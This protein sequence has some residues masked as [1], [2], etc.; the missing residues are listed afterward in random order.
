MTGQLSFEVQRRL[1]VAVARLSG[2]LD[3]YTAADLRTGLLSC[4]AE[5]PSAIVMDTTALT[6]ADDIGLLALAGVAQLSERWPGCGF[7]AFG[8]AAEFAPA[9]ERM[10]VSQYVKMCPDLTTALTEADQWPVP[11]TARARI[12]PDRNAPSVARAAVHEFCRVEGIGGDG[13]A[14][15]LVASELVTNA[16]VHAGTTIDLTLRLIPPLLHIAVRDGGRG[17]ARIG[18]VVDESSES[19]RGLLLVDALAASW[20]TF[21]PDAGKVVWATVRVKPRAASALAG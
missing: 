4:L 14:A 19:G 16:V 18:G 12:D 1:P 10:G 2:V 5:Q 13:D 6:V 8:G 17:Q 9:M 15:Q 7:V 11:P 20:G 3:A 21:V